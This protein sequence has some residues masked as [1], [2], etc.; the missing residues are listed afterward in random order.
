[1]DAGG[2]DRLRSGRGGRG[3]RRALHG[4][5]HDESAGDSGTGSV[6][7]DATHGNDWYGTGGGERPGRG[8]SG[9]VSGDVDGGTVG[10]RKD[11][12][13]VD[14]GAAAVGWARCGAAQRHWCLDGGCGAGDSGTVA[15]R[16]PGRR[17]P[18]ASGAGGPDLAGGGRIAGGRHLCRAHHP[19]LDD[20]RPDGRHRPAGAGGWV[21]IFTTNY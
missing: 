12:G 3:W 8:E 19:G 7:D 21:T 17:R 11:R 6:G 9:G 14:G 10:R 16:V 5:G 1:M 20:G 2:A 13:L 15:G 4:A 18:L